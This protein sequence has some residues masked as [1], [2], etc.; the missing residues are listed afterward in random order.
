MEVCDIENFPLQTWVCLNLSLRNNVL[1]IF[2]NGHLVK[3]CIMKGVQQLMQVI[4]LSA[5]KV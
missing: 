4:Y 5:K 2:M 3:S 1:D